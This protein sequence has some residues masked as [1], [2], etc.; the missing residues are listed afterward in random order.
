MQSFAKTHTG[1]GRERAIA[2][3][4]STEL[5]HHTGLLG[6]G[7]EDEFRID[8]ERIRFSPYFSR[9]SADRKSVV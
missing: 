2:E 6:S 8:I 1:G 7:N 9:L 3:P 5:E 4:A